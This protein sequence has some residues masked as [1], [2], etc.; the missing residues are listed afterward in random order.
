[1]NLLVMYNISVQ[2]VSRIL[3]TSSLKILPLTA[4]VFVKRFRSVVETPMLTFVS[5]LC[6][7]NMVAI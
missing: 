2:L 7:T 4:L 3:I 5:Q 6:G 1:M